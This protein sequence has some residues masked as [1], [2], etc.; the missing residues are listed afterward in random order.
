MTVIYRRC[1]AARNLLVLRTNAKDG[2][3]DVGFRCA[4][5]LTFATTFLLYVF[6]QIAF[7]WPWRMF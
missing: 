3:G 2:R 5:Y 1:G 6:P 7:V 4:Q